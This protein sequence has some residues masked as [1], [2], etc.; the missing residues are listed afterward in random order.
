M[1]AD[2]DTNKPRYTMLCEASAEMV[3]L[4]EEPSCFELEAKTDKMVRLW[5]EVGEL[6]TSYPTLFYPSLITLIILNI[7]QLPP[8][9][10]TSSWFS[11]TLWLFIQ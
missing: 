2:L 10:N 4:I 9:F 3:P 5:N 8:L 7:S 6:L 1:Q 11:P